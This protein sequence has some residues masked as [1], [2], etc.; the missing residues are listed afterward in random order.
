MSNA[1]KFF[2]NTNNNA[3][4]LTNNFGCMLNLLDACLVN[5]VQVG[6]ISSLSATGTTATAVFSAAH[7][8]TIFQ[9]IQIEGA[10]QAEYNVEA[11][12][13]TIPNSTTITFK[14]N[15]AP[16]V[17]PATGD[18]FAKLP[19]LGWEKKFSST[20]ATG[21]KGAY[22]STNTALSSRPFLRV[23]DEL[24]PAYT[25]TFAKYAKVGIVEDMTDIDT[26]LGVQAPYDSAAI[27]KNWIGTGTGTSVV[28]GWARWYYAGSS[29]GYYN[30]NAAVPAGN[31]NWILVGDG[32]RFYL[33][34]SFIASNTNL[35]PYGFGAYKSLINADTSN[36]FLSATISLSTAGTGIF[37]ADSVPL[38]TSSSQ[39]QIILLRNYAQTA[40]YTTAI[41]TSMLMGG[42]TLY[43]GYM[44]YIGAYT[45]TNVAPFIPVFLNETVLRGELLGLY[46]LLQAKPYTHLQIIVKDNEIYMAVNGAMST[47]QL[48][49]M[50]VKIGDMH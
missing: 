23:V 29:D 9:V 21:G 6:L 5:G 3:P 16:S 19:S 48:G 28:N 18:I 37:H 47:G 49:Q 13:L 12:V 11:Q 17:S 50:I 7:N 34:V 32:D 22:R 31:R 4:Q 35:T 26:M 38:G 14:L 41:C 1:I 10:N 25:A 39:A 43:S 2:T 42:G 15:V 36:T 24:D 27:N 30:D 8:L 44:N 45:L 40:Q 33:F 20:S 46:W